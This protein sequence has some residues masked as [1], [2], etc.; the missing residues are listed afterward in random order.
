MCVCACVC[1]QVILLQPTRARCVS[2]CP[3][4]HVCVFCPSVCTR[5]GLSIS[6]AISEKK[7]FSL[8]NC[9]S[10]SPLVNFS[11][12]LVHFCLFFS[13]CSLS[14]SFSRSFIFSLSAVAPC[15]LFVSVSS[16]ACVSPHRCRFIHHLTINRCI[17]STQ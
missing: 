5:R 11:L 2:I 3:G 10:Y 16:H 9:F 1:V 4:V 7:E 6:A 15:L 17:L 13:L 14:I 12:P 8:G